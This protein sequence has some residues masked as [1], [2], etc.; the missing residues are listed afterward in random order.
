M[1]NRGDFEAADVSKMMDLSLF[2]QQPWQEDP[3]ARC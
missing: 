1:N 3:G 2:I